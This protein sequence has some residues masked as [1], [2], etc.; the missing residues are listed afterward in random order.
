M[1]IGG[2]GIVNMFMNMALKKNKLNDTNMK[3]IFPCFFIFKWAELISSWN[4]VRQNTMGPY[5]HPT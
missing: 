2:K 5:S 3:N 1:Q 4:L